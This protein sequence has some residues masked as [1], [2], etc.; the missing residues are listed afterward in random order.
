MTKYLTDCYESFQKFSIE[1]FCKDKFGKTYGCI[2]KEYPN[3][4]KIVIVANHIFRLIPMIALMQVLPF[5]MAANC[6]LMMAGGLFY[7]VTIERLCPLK[8]SMLSCFG[9]VA[10]EFARMNA[11]NPLSAV[12]LAIYAFS[13]LN[14][15][16]SY[17]PS[18]CG[19]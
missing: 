18:C 16:Y 14:T 8:F 3:L 9:S 1:T 6:A 13:V 12:P 15:A 4:N 2:A 7:R 10:F 17:K 11:F 19:S 5:S